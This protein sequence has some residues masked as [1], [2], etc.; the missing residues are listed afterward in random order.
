MIAK[1]KEP[2]SRK[3][4]P[5]R[6]YLKNIRGSFLAQYVR[7]NTDSNFP[8]RPWSHRQVFPFSWFPYIVLVGRRE[9]SASTLVSRL[10]TGRRFLTIY[11]NSAISIITFVAMKNAWKSVAKKVTNIFLFIYKRNGTKNTHSV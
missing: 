3:P 5:V 6:S 11:V 8:M 9:P 1:L 4:E 10:K 7:Y 2:N